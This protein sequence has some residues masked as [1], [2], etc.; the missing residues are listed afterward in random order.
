M[1][2]N[3]IIQEKVRI[4]GTEVLKIWIKATQRL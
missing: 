4:I 3:L 1:S 2:K